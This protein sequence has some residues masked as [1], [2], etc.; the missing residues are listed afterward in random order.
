MQIAG[1]HIQIDETRTLVQIQL[2]S[3]SGECLA[4]TVVLWEN[5]GGA[6]TQWGTVSVPA[7]GSAS[8]WISARVTTS[9]RAH[10]AQT[11]TRHAAWSPIFL[12]HNYP[13]KPVV[14]TPSW[15]P[16]PRLKPAQVRAVGHGPNPVIAPITNAGWAQMT[17]ASWHP[18][19]PVG[20]SA[21]RTLSV[22][23]WGFD[24]YRHRGTLVIAAWAARDFVGA[25]SAFYANAIPLRYLY[26]VDV[27]GWSSATNGG[28][29]YASM[30]ADN[31]SAFD[32]RWVDGSPG[33]MS[34][35]SW[36]AAVDLNTFENPYNS[37][38]GWT[39]TAAW[40]KIAIA[41]YSWRRPSDKV[42]SI[43]RANGFS[44]TYGTNDPQHFD[45]H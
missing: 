26:P 35:H 10:A 31:T 27:F 37:A 4:G 11:P 2:K 17:K 39:P 40:A 1:T 21:L 24:G 38:T 22:N 13:P 15:L 30:Q 32:C 44:W 25:F 28:N 45:A 7:S 18:G 19:C 16:H 42:V 23:Y 8:V 41:P 34:P 6:W 12:L 36:G 29:D 3:P 14:T 33:V 5:L 9:W 43:M 20:R